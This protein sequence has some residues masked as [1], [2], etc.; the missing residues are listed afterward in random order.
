MLA[1]FFKAIKQTPSNCNFSMI[2]WSKNTM[3][4]NISLLIFLAYINQD[5]IFKDNF[6]RC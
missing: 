5:I 6:V 2:L 1:F 3:I 4:N